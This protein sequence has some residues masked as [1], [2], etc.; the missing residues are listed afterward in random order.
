MT[1]QRTWPRL[2]DS[3]QRG[4]VLVVGLIVL[5]IMTIVGVASL[6]STSIEEKMAGNLRD[7][8]IALQ[9]TESTIREAETVIDGLANTTGFG[10]SGGFYSLGNAPDPFS[11]GTW[12]GASSN[13]STLNLGNAIAPRYY[14][15]LIGE[16]SD[17][18]GTEVNILNYGQ[19]QG[20]AV[21]VFRVVGRGTGA[22]GTAQV[23]IESFY[24]RRF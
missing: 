19:A 9:A 16:F 6:Q 14:I 24:G 18:T 23:I 1:R 21:T 7:L 20:G 11:A 13:V 15:E 10:A 8:N 17:E 12:T 5:I 22:T 2:N 4:A 3:R